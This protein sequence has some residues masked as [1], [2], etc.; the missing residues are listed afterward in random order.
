M[1]RGK[2][3]WIRNKSSF[4]G[5]CMLLFSVLL[6]FLVAQFPDTANEYRTIS[7]AF[8]PYML[9]AIMMGLSLL[10]ILESRRSAPASLFSIRFDSQ[11]AYRTGLLLLILVI[12]ALM[13]TTLG[14]ALGSMLFM[15]AAQL[16]LGE[17]KFLPLILFTLAVPWAMYFVF[18]KLFKIPLPTGPWF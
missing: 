8:F 4:L 5:T 10:L 11:A 17:R 1:E 9:S 18:G 12:F 16:L 7:P 2:R 3:L 14:F 13:L 15:L 6:F